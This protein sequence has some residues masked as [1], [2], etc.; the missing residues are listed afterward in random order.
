MIGSTPSETTSRPWG[1]VSST[2]FGVVDA[3]PTETTDAS[4]GGGCERGAGADGPRE[5]EP[6]SS[7]ERRDER[8]D[9]MLMVSS[10]SAS[11]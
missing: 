5:R 6:K 3:T 11:C 8:R 1:H 4:V 7:R 9:D 2:A 10:A